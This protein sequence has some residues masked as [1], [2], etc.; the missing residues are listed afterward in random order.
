MQDVKE[1][2]KELNQ[3]Q[4]SLK[5]IKSPIFEK[6]NEETEE[7]KSQR[8]PTPTDKKEKKTVQA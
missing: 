1:K 8:T 5:I 6:E 3:S 7:E 2:Q 4:T